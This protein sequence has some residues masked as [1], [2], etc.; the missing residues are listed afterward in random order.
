MLPTGLPAKLALVVTRSVTEL[1]LVGG[2]PALDFANTLEGPRDG[3]PGDEHLREPADLDAWARYAGVLVS[4]TACD[5]R[6]FARAHTLRAA[7]YDAFRAIAAG[8]SPPAGALDTL[9][10]FYASAVAH[11]RL[12]PTSGGFDLTWDADDPERVLWP[13]AAAAVDLLRSGPLE[14]VEMCVECRWLFL[15]QSR[16]H[17]RRWCSM[18]ECGGRSKMRRYRARRATRR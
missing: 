3:D 9:A 16:N 17:S 13:L 5:E 12:A 15:D 8:T 6:V 7:V 11:A 2:N 1:E 14:R 4:A 10:G 18:N